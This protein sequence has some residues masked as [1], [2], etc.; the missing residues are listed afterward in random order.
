[1]VSDHRFVFVIGMHRSGTTM[2]G[3][4]IARHSQ[5]SGLSDTGVNMNEGSLVQ[6]AIPLPPGLGSLAFK[7]HARHDETS[8]Y[9]TPEVARALWAAWSPHWD[10]SRPVLVEKSPN[11]IM[12]TRLLQALFPQSSFVCI[13]RHPIAQAAAISKWASN[14]TRLQFLA[15]W[16]LCHR[17]LMA[18]LPHLRRSILFRYEDFCTAPEAHMDAILDFL[19]L[20][21][22]PLIDRRIAA[23]NERY[24]DL[25]QSER[26]LSIAAQRLAGRALLSRGFARFGYGMVPPFLGP[27]PSFCI[28]PG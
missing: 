14:R 26:G 4:L 8:A 10:L 3:D 1:M 24:F 23:S 11:H 15:N 12:S 17:R 13:L 28:A 7:P 18:D 20:P 5:A 2:L 9:A 6:T 22:E 25:W 16:A 27:R 19:D 21:R